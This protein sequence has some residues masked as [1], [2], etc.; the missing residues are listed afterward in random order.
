M[1]FEQSRVVQGQAVQWGDFF[2]SFISF[3]LSETTYLAFFSTTVG[4]KLCLGS[5]VVHD[6]R[7]RI[8]VSGTQGVFYGVR[9]SKSLHTWGEGIK[10]PPQ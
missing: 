8:G 2:R 7:V 4:G 10:V 6:K 3:L 5:G 1:G 9:A